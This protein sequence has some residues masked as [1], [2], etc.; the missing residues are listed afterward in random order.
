MSDCVV[1]TSNEQLDMGTTVDKMIMATNLV[2][3]QDRTPF[4]KSMYDV[5][6]LNYPKEL[7]QKKQQMEQLQNQQVGGPI[8]N[9]MQQR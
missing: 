5:M 6:G 1:H 9:T 3:E 8:E 7:S 4:V 2:P